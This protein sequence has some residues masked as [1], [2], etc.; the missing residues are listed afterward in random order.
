[1]AKKE[2]KRGTYL[3]MVLPSQIL[4]G[5]TVGEE[6][7][8]R[9]SDEAGGCFSNLKIHQE[10]KRARNKKLLRSQKTAEPKQGQK[11]EIEEM[12]NM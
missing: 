12:M 1:M 2:R 8:S 6:G 9:Y 11:G 5:V 7:R 3:C 10:G 4:Y